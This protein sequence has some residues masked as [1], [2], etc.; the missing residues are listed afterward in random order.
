MGLPSIAYGQSNNADDSSGVD[1]SANLSI[2]T[3]YRFRGI[4]L[5]DRDPALQGG[6]DIGTS[7]GFFVG[8]WASTIADTGGSNV[9]VDLYGGYANTV[10]G[11]DYSGM[12]VGYVYPGG[13]DVNYYELFGNAERTVGA[14]TVKLEL[15]YIPEQNAYS[16]SNFY[17]NTGADV[18][19]PQTP[20]MLNVGVGRESSV[21]FKKWDW[22][23]GLS[24]SYDFLT[25]S[26]AYVD[27]NYDNENEAGRL[28]RAAAV[29]SLTADF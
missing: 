3:D 26:A 11:T 2:V 1:I 4:S 7:A 18:E 12:V 24:W 27:T 25:L 17:V 9:E 15:A 22:I 20:L 29:I 28:G 13:E 8:T 16:D 14:A 23:A 5:S 6:L 19:L 10:A 21:G